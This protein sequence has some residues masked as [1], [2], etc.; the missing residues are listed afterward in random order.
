MVSVDSITVR[1]SEYQHVWSVL[2]VLLS[3]CQNINMYGEPEHSYCQCQNIQYGII[4]HFERCPSW[5][6]MLA[7][8]AP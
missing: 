4:R 2:T 8:T 3:E 5:I 6:E 7:R 1:V